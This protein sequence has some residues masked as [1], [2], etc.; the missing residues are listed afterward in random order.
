MYKDLI[1]FYKQKKR[2][3]PNFVSDST[4]HIINV[5]TMMKQSKTLAVVALM[6]GSMGMTAQTAPIRIDFNQ[7]GAAVSPDLYGI[8]FEEINHAGDGG[9]Y[10]ELVQMLV[11]L[12][13]KFIRWPG[14]CIVEG[15]TYENRVKW[16]ETLGDPMTRRGEWDN[17]NPCRS[18]SCV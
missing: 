4:N 14:G 9:L 17:S 5:T 8:F 18:P 12:H 13:P 11:D 16:K 15:A 3:S 6:A 10:A 1:R 2:K 7:R